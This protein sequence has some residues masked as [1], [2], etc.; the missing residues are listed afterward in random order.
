[1]EIDEKGGQGV[2]AEGQPLMMA[3]HIVERDDLDS[4]CGNGGRGHHTGMQPREA[5]GV[6][7]Y[8]QKELAGQAPADELEDPGIG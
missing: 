2:V 8:E 6:P 4:D 7:A 1:M 3:A 5:A